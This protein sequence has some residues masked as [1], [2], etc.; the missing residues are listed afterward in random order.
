MPNVFIPFAEEIG[1]IAPIDEWV[2][3]EACAT[4]ATWTWPDDLSVSVNL[5]P[6]QFGAAGRLLMAPMLPSSIRPPLSWRS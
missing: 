1:V 6:V 4:A 5:S 2:M 3:K